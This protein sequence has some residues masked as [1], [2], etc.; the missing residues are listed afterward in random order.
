MRGVVM[1]V[2][3]AVVTAGSL[4]LGGCGS[5]PASPA[6]DLGALVDLAEVADTPTGESTDAAT[7]P[8][9]PDGALVCADAGK[10]TRSPVPC[11]DGTGL[12]V[13]CPGLLRDPGQPGDACDP[14]AQPDLCFNPCKYGLH[15][16]QM[17]AQTTDGEWKLGYFRWNVLELPCT[18]DNMPLLVDGGPVTFAQLPCDDGT[19]RTNCCPPGSATDVACVITDTFSG[20]T[21]VTPCEAGITT[22]LECEGLFLP[23]TPMACGPDGGPD[24]GAD[25]GADLGDGPDVMTGDVAGGG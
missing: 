8:Y 1:V 4:L 20:H 13:C 3:A 24:L 21:C 10:V 9:A 18:A 12:S 19:V 6:P 5:R 23:G 14:C 15:T 22:E 11:N 7:G 16:P 25:A 17:C 2:L